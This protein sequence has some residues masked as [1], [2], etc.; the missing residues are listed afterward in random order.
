MGEGAAQPKIVK[1][2]RSHTLDRF[3]CGV[4]SLN[5]FIKQYALT[6]QSS[7]GR[8]DLCRRPSAMS[9]WAITAWRRAR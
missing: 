8:P 4:A 3:D 7:G 2:D 1:L 5:N 9:W 6:N